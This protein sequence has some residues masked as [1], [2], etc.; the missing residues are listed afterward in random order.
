[1]PRNK[2]R[3]SSNQKFP[4]TQ[5][6]AGRSERLAAADRLKDEVIDLR[7]V[8]TQ[9]LAGHLRKVFA[10]GWCIRDIVRALEKTPAGEV[11]QTRGAGGMRSVLA[12]LHLRL[13]AWGSEDDGSLLPSPTANERAEAQRVREV[14]ITREQA[15]R[16]RLAK[17][18]V[19]PVR[20][21]EQVRLM[22]EFV[23]VKNRWGLNEAARLYPEQAQL[24]E[25]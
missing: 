18:Q 11:Y 7:R 21:L 24:L 10:S 6:P 16:T 2:T 8:P 19:V 4:S 5:I 25:V 20:G 12:W 1:M 13:K 3:G 17:A 23:K 15:T 14:A 22:R 9:L